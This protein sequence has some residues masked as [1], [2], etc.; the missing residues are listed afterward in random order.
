ML[1]AMARFDR[2]ERDS[3]KWRGWE[4]KKKFKY[5]IIHEQRL[6][7][8]KEI[9]SLATGVPTSDF[10][11]GAQANSTVRKIGLTVEALHLPG[12]DKVQIAL[13][14]LLLMKAPSAI[15]P[16]QAHETLA[17]QF[18]LS[19][20]LRNKRMENSDELHWQDRV[21]CARHK[22]VEAGIIDP[23]ERGPWKL[24]AR[25]QSKVWIEKGPHA[26]GIALRSP[27]RARD[28]A[29]IYR[30]MRLVQPGDVI[31]HLTDNAAFTG[32]SI[33]KALAEIDFIG[34]ETSWDRFP[35]YRIGLRA[36]CPLDPPLTREMLASA[37]GLREKLVAIRQNHADLFYDPNLLYQGGYL[38]EA[39]PE[40]VNLLDQTYRNIVGRPLL[41]QLSRQTPPQP[42]APSEPGNLVK[43]LEKPPTSRETRIKAPEYSIEAF[44]AET[45][46]PSATIR[47]WK[48]RLE[49]KQHV[50]FQGPPGTGKTYIAERLARLLISGSFGFMETLQFH[51]SYS[52]EDFIQGIRPMTSGGQLTFERVPGRFM[53]FCEKA[54]RIPEAAPCVLIID[55]INRGNLSRIFGEL[56][57]L[58][59]Y[60]DKAIPIAGESLP[61][62]IPANVFLIGTMNTADRSI[63]L[64]DHALRRR[65]SF[66]HLGPDY[67]AL[68]SQLQHHGLPAKPLVD[69]LRAVNAA[70]E[71]CNYA[72][73]I[74][75]FLKD[76][77]G[78][79]HT[80][81]D[82]W[83]GEIEP[84]LEEFFYDQ[85]DKVDPFRWKNLIAGRLAGWDKEL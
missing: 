32:V 83:E 23:S 19:P 33:A 45:A 73:G 74:S 14:E 42:S 44:S 66:I 64:V 8:V 27:T 24:R 71:D 54:E 51:P 84:Y 63:A 18:A 68:Q 17:D 47:K 35:F 9:I 52:Y 4:T 41:S 77:Q 31:L 85:P 30:N 7:P 61:F 78:L 62:R 72:V 43:D 11:G 50:V 13:H 34:L 69:T 5:A 67:D 59:E 28:G 76:G 22:L 3:A 57:Y 12:E 56:M 65:F 70:I 60:R 39:P 36:F 2:E 29:D 15:E 58:L 20:H 16:A 10:G 6:Y 38:T 80:L 21:R 75:F 55:E 79:R 46:L 40:L 53:Q 26:L 81:P 49:R 25:M 48:S 82:V 37:T 1:E